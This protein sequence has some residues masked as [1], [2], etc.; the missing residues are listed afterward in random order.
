MEPRDYTRLLT[1]NNKGNVSGLCGRILRGKAEG[2][3]RTLTDDSSRKVVMLVG[4]DGLERLLGKNGYD[5]LIEIGYEPDY[6]E[7]KLNE[8]TQF[9]LAVFKE[10]AE[11][12]PATWDNTRELLCKIYPDVSKKLLNSMTRLKEI[13]G[14]YQSPR[15]AFKAL[16]TLTGHSFKD[17][18]AIGD[19]DMRYMTYDRYR[20]ITER[21]VLEEV[22]NTRA[23]LYFAVYLKELYSGD[24]YTYTADGRKGL[25]EYIV[26][27]LPLDNLGTHELIK[28]DVKKSSQKPVSSGGLP[29]HYDPANATKVMQIKYQAIAEGA[30]DWASRH[31]LSPAA[32]DKLK[33]CLMVIDMQNTFCLPN[34][35]LYVAGAEGDTNRLCEFIYKNLG[36]I[37]N[38][39][40]TMDTHLG[41]QIFHPVFWIDED[42]NHPA[43]GATIISADDVKKGKWRINPGV[44]HVAGG[45]YIGLQKH[46]QHYVEKLSEDGKYSLLVWPYHG[47]LGGV[48]HALVG[49]VEEAM[50]FHSIARNS[51]TRFE[52]KGGNPLTENYSVLRPEVL[53][54]HKGRPIA[55]KNAAFI[56][57]LLDYDVVVIAGQAKSHCVAWTIQDLLN[58]INAKDP[59]LVRKVYLL[60]DCTSPVV[61]PGV[62]DFTDQ[63]NEAFRKFASAGMNIVKSTDPI[64]SWSGVK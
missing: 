45:D 47:M 62:I 54:D 33:V 51:Q 8:G 24:G 42:G 18:D 53:E 32:K 14:K 41:M 50:F 52:I 64:L 36:T 27:N 17:V 26:P 63:A 49:S 5:M 2:D 40:P 60:E 22:I 48:G 55:Q 9:R 13:Y 57:K 25:M 10:G 35:E 28:L 30:R 37:T 31:N 44:S 16:E 1:S 4:P 34:G 23:F 56:K 12:S 15:E 11:A 58:E 19:S 39:A 43:P 29:N 59:S 6:I 3:F 61:I 38:I 21:S 7:Q 46:A 20:Y